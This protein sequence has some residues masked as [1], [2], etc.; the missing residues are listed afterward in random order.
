MTSS[1]MHVFYVHAHL[2]EGVSVDIYSFIE[3][4]IELGARF[5]HLTSVTAGDVSSDMVCKIWAV[6]MLTYCHVSLN[7][8]YMTSHYGGVKVVQ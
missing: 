5:N 1:R 4:S 8:S 6:N 7:Y 3:R 2:T